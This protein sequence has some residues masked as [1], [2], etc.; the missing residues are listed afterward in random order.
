M[1][2]NPLVL[3]AHYHAPT[4]EGGKFLETKIVSP[5]MSIEQALQWAMD[6]SGTAI[7]E[8]VEISKPR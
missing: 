5:T 3:I 7:L 2:E 1:E 4:S 6:N 8:R